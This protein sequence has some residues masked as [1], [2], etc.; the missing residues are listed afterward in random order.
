MRITTVTLGAETPN[1]NSSRFSGC[2]AGMV[3]NSESINLDIALMEA[4][5]NQH[6]QVSTHMAG[7]GC[8][9]GNP[10]NGVQC[11]DNTVCEAGWQ[12]YSC[13]CNLPNRVI[14]NQCVIPCSTEPCKNGGT[15]EVIRFGSA[16]FQCTCPEGYPLPT[17][18][19]ED[20]GTCHVGFYD[21]PNCNEQCLCDPRGAEAQ[22]C[23][24]NTGACI[25]KV[26]QSIP[27]CL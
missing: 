19:D 8:G 14:N 26:G 2:L 15:C 12:N 9:Q 23:D 24:S 5:L 13:V 22:I 6:F 16:G 11:P 25:C 17:C 4:L 7:S 21:P 10:C 20:D 1:S 27:Y 18:E 3:I